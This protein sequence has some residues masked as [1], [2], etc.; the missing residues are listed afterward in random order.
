M[1][2]KDDLFSGLDFEEFFGPEHNSS[3]KR[4]RES[5]TLGYRYPI[6]FAACR[7]KEIK[8]KLASPG[9]IENR[10]QFV[11]LQSLSDP[12]STATHPEL[13]YLPHFLVKYLQKFHHLELDLPVSDNF[14]VCVQQCIQ[15]TDEYCIQMYIVYS[16]IQLYTSMYTAVYRCIHL[17]TLQS[18]FVYILTLF[19]L[20]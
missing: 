3:V 6:W 15:Y 16:C 19:K 20:V 2:G 18:M 17:D 14:F 10:T 4:D 8:Y 7:H 12:Q 1:E 11:M 9:S 5:N 13:K